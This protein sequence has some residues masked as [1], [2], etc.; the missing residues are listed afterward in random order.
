MNGAPLPPEAVKVIGPYRTVTVPEGST[1]G[2]T[3]VSAALH[4]VSVG[5]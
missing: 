5:L 4:V 2:A 3:I 1:S